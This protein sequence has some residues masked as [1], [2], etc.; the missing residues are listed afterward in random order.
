MAKYCKLENGTIQYFKNPLIVGLSSIYNPSEDVLYQNGYKPFV[1]SYID[2]SQEKSSD[3]SVSY[4]ESEESITQ[5]YTYTPNPTKI[6][7]YYTQEIQNYLDSEAKKLGYDSCLSVCSYINTGIPKFDAEGE[8]FRTWRS[9]VW[10]YGYE[11]LNKALAGEIE[12]PTLQ[13]FIS[14]LPQLVITYP[15]V[16]AE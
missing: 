11:T 2:A 4:E 10:A 3:V 14:S 7:S 15:E 13:D 5:V 1:P 16:E 6:Q 12:I 8:A 9:A